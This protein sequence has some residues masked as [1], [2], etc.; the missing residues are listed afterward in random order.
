MLFL[1]III[2]FVVVILYYCS[3]YFDRDFFYDAP[4]MYTKIKFQSFLKFYYINPDAW[5]LS[6]SFIKYKQSK[7]YF[8]FNWFEVPKYH[9]WHEQIKKNKLTKRQTEKYQ[10]TLE[11]IKRDLEWFNRKNEQMIKK[12]AEKMAKHVTDIPSMFVDEVHPVHVYAK[13]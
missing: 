1:F 4:D 2:I 3:L 10:E 7:A 5:E 11:Y 9:K 8:E 12:E 6:D 13:K